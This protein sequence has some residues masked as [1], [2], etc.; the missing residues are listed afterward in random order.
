MRQTLWLFSAAI[1]LLI[2]S[3]CT[4]QTTTEPTVELPKNRFQPAATVLQLHEAMIDPSSDAIFK[5]VETPADDAAWAGVRNS[6]VILTESGNL[7]MIASRA[8]DTGDWMNHSQALAEGG[9][10]ALRAAEKKDPDA[11]LAAGDK[12]VPVCMACHEKYRDGGR[13][14]GK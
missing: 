11:L 3:A 5:G 12:I 2:A 1:L 7:L 13:K 4:Q 10:A 6:A 9:A 8:K 14:M